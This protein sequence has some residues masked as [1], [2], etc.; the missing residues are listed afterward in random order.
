[1]FRINLCYCPVVPKVDIVRVFSHLSFNL[2]LQ[3]SS[4]LK[5]PVPPQL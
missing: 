5:N 4:S 2:V 3:T 1:L